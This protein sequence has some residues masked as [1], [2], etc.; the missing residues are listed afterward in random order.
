LC[1]SLPVAY[2]FIHEC[3]ALILNLILISLFFSIIPK[4]RLSN[5]NSELRLAQK[6]S[7]SVCMKLADKE[8]VCSTAEGDLRV[9]REWR[10]SLQETSLKDKEK[11]SNLTQKL[12]EE[13]ARNR[14]G[15]LLKRK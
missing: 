13:K 10:I 15:T 7:R 9:E 12:V 14:V 5:A 1:F 6:E 2:L 8:L 11:I 3:F 4:I